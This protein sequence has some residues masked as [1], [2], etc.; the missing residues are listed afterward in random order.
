MAR[1][2]AGDAVFACS[3]IRRDVARKPL[4]DSKHINIVV[5]S[6]PAYNSSHNLGWQRLKDPNSILPHRK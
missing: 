4:E 6:D 3:K 5:D 1:W 2:L